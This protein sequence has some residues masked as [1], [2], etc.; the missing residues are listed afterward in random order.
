[1]IKK[2]RK[3]YTLMKRMAL[4]NS[5]RILYRIKALCDFDDVKK[6][7]LGGFVESERNLS[8]Y[9]NCWI[10][11][12]AIAYGSGRVTENAKIYDKVKVYGNAEVSGDAYI[13]GNVRVRDSAWVYGV[14]EI[15]GA[16]SIKGTSEVRNCFISGSLDITG[17]A[18]INK[19]IKTED[20]YITVGPIGSRNDITTFIRTDNGIYVNCGCFDGTIDEFKDDVIEMHG[21]NRHAKDYLAA[22]EFVTK[23][24]NV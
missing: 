17:N 3:K 18:V 4:H 20:D 11:N 1:M 16:V 22:I 7:D 15:D 19:N 13:Y 24:F 9:G 6:G 23:K 8:Q 14:T 2:I 21:D 5:G 12:D 10:Y